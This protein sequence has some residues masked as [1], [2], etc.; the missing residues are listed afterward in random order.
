[1]YYFGIDPGS[2]GAI[3]IIDVTFIN[4]YPMPD[5][6]LDLAKILKLATL[7]RSHVFVEKAQAMSR[8]RKG[9]A[10]GMFTYGTGYGIILGILA[11][12]EL[13]HTLVHPKTWCKAMH[14]GTR[15]G[16]P[17]QRSLEAARRLFPTVELKRTT[18][19]SKPDEGFIDALL[20]AE[21]GRRT[22]N[23]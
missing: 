5:N 6:A 13:P 7:S 10:T 18:R 9:G 23:A 8:E 22:I 16:M 21:Y 1:M 12:L 14:A 4:L 17:K 3:A 20:I 19:C 11:A 15:A 2:K